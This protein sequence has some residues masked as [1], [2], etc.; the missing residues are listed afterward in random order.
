MSRIGKKPIHVPKNIEINIK[1]KTLSIKGPHGTLNKTVPTELEINYEN[2]IITLKKQENSKKASAL[3]GLYRSLIQNM[4]TGVSEKFE[5]TLEMIGV[6]YRA[7]VEGKKLVLNVGYS[8]PIIFD[9]PENIEASV[10]NNIN[11]LLKGID[12]EVVGEFA[13]KIRFTRP[14]EPYKGKGILYKGEV[15][16][17]KVGKSGK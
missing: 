15:I 14:P 3:F 6:G 11:I 10:E 17:R 9:L 16:R 2:N 12:K 5:K 7:K 1:D 8:H 4:V 13:S